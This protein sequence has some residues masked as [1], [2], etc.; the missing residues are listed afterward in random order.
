[1]NEYTEMKC[2]KCGG[3]IEYDDSYDVYRGD[4]FIIDLCVGHCI[5]CSSDYQWKEA[6][7]LKFDSVVDFEEVK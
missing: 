4:D 7:T 6:F 3:I 2:P 1:M 5:D